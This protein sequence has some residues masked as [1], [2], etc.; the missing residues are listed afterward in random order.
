MFNLPDDKAVAV[1]VFYVDAHNHPAVVD[2]AVT[3]SSSDET[4][5]TVTVDPADSTKAR[6]AAGAGLGQVQITAKADAD[7][8]AGIR[9]LLTMLDVT[10][11]AGEA[12]SGVIQPTSDPVPA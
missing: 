8:G 1:Q 2:G 10:V 6:V 11:V 9:E 12:V 7:L 3:W 4:I 5:A